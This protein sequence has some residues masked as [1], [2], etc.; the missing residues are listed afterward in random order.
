MTT[1]IAQNGDTA[2]VAT[3]PS[4]D[5]CNPSSRRQG[6][7]IEFECEMCH[8]DMDDGKKN[9]LPPFQLA[10]LQH[11]GNTYIEWV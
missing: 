6:L 5:T 4:A 9:T 1:V 8:G 7:S 3:F 11:K 2:Q 10:I